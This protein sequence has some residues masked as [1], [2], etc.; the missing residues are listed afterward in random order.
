M[1]TL[2][3]P[4]VSIIMPAYN[5]QRFL[6]EAIESILNQSFKDFEFLVMDDGSTDNTWSILQYYA[7]KDS[8]IRL[9]HQENKGVGN[10][11]NY[12]IEM[13]RA[14]L[15]ARMDADDISHPERLQQ[16]VNYLRDNPHIG[17]L[18]T[19]RITIAPNGFSCDFV[20]PPNAPVLLADLFAKDINLITHGSVM[21]RKEV[22]KSLNEPPYKPIRAQDLD[23]W[24]RLIKLTAFSVINTPLYSLRQYSGSITNRWDNRKTIINNQYKKQA[25]AKNILTDLENKVAILLRMDISSD[26]GYEYF[27][28]STA[29][30]FNK[31]YLQALNTLT[32]VFFCKNKKYKFKS[33]ILMGLILLGPLGLLIYQKFKNYQNYH[34]I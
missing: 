16:Q 21:M 4:T 25:E 29:L 32:R 12:L 3:E 27:L 17:M 9:F 30:F 26:Q 1:N 33:L 10:S 7:Q 8:R 23:L 18:S 2:K 22:L 14:E 31:R 11:L 34:S 6:S 19:A 5:A 15:I 20:C 28:N 24:K 13:S